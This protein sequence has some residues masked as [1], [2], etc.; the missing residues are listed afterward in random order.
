M[1]LEQWQQARKVLADALELQQRPP[2]VFGSCLPFGHL[3]EAGSQTGKRSDQLLVRLL[4]HTSVLGFVIMEIQVIFF[5]SVR[6]Q[7]HDFGIRLHRKM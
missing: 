3:N 7:K 6:K 5:S 2:G 4:A 1:K